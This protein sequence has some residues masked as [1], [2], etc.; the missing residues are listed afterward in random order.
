[1]RSSIDRALAASQSAT[2]HLKKHLQTEDRSARTA[3]EHADAWRAHLRKDGPLEEVIITVGPLRFLRRMDT[4]GEYVVCQRQIETR[5]VEVSP[6]EDGLERAL[7]EM[8][9]KR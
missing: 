6:G 1:M 2:R 7:L 3:A 8:H 4:H 9:K 5:W